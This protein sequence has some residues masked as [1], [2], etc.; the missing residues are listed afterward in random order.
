MIQKKI[1]E[2][3]LADIQS[4]VTLSV[5]ESKVIEYKKELKVGSDSEKK[6]FLYDIS[7]FANTSG[8][9]LIFGIEESAGMPVSLVPLLIPDLDAQILQLENI[10]R[11]GVA[12]RISFFIHAIPTDTINGYILTV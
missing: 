8:G 6:E 3:E 2:I 5:A 1:N 4:L 7:S 11:M 9:D 10:I 12:P